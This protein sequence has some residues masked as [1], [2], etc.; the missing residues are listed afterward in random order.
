VGTVVKD[1]EAL[2]LAREAAR[3][4]MGIGVSSAAVVISQVYP[5]TRNRAEGWRL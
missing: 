2:F 1:D 5:V 4:R 3:R